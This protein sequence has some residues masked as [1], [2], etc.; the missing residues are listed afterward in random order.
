LHNNG[1]HYDK[2]DFEITLRGKNYKFVNG[3]RVSFAGWGD[4]Y[5]FFDELLDLLIEIVNNPALQKVKLIPQT[6]HLD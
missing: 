6:S 1:F 3:D 4:L 2:Y 5:V